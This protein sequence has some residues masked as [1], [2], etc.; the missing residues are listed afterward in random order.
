[1]AEYIDREA[2][3]KSACKGCTRHGVEIG[4]CFSDEPCE[5]LIIAFASAPA[6]DVVERK[7]GE[8]VEHKEWDFKAR[9]YFLAGY[10]CSCCG[11][12]YLNHNKYKYC[13]DCGAD[14]R[15]VDSE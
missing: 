3:Y 13:P 12:W 9:D 7:R 2:V 11:H 1:M 15:G 8:W 10:H 5:R 6:A 4:S 14:M